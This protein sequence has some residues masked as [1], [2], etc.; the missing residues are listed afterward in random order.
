MGKQCRY[1][2]WIEIDL[3]VLNHNI[4]ALRSHLRLGTKFMAVVK[5]NAYGCGA[6]TISRAALEAGAEYL[7]VYSLEEALELREAGM[8]APLLIMGPV[9]PDRADTVVKQRLTPTVVEMELARALSHAGKKLDTVAEVHVKIDTGLHRF[10]VSIE[11]SPHLIRCI[12]ELFNIKVAGLYTHFSSADETDQTP[13]K[14]QLKRFLKLARLF[15]QIKLLHAANS[16]ATLQF[17]ETHLD[18]VRVGISIYGFYPSAAVRKTVLLKPVLSLKT[19]V[20]TV[21]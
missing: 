20:E 6:L 3:N 14:V 12:G 9:S 19:R 4:K 15:P 8:H 11:E 1:F 13:T 18:M 2:Q 7:G 17:P 16:A 10:G 21:N 5:R